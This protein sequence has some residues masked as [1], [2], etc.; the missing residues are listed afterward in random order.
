MGLGMR[1][2][3]HVQRVAFTLALVVPLAVLVG[4]K[5]EMVIFCTIYA[6]GVGIVAALWNRKTVVAE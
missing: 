2:S 6:W 5:Q 4:G 1:I 3:Y